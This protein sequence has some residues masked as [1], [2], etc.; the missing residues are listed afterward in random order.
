MYEIDRHGLE[1]AVLF[2]LRHYPEETV[3]ATIPQ[4]VADIKTRYPE[5]MKR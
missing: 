3:I 1:M 2:A 5:L 4:I